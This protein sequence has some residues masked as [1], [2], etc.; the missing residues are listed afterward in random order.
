MRARIVRKV[1]NKVEREYAGGLIS[2]AILA[3]LAAK[4]G[5]E[6]IQIRHL[7]K[8]RWLLTFWEEEK[9]IRGWK[10]QYIVSF[11][12][13]DALYCPYR[14]GAEHVQMIRSVFGD[15][16]LQQIA[17]WVRIEAE[18]NT[19]LTVEIP[20]EIACG[21]DVFR[22]TNY[23]SVLTKPGAFQNFLVETPERD[24]DIYRVVARPNVG[25]I[26]ERWVRHG[27]PSE[28]DPRQDEKQH[29]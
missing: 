21:L 15:V 9:K 27:C 4:R 6:A 2:V 8:N 11:R 26:I 25:A 29:P 1:L 14:T 23:V 16:P 3:A 19:Y 10:K 7:F 28:W 13:L 17:E 18:G 24:G 5:A 20:K 22:E 12:S